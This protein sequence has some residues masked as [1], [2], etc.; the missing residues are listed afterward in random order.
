MQVTNILILI[1]GLSLLGRSIAEEPIVSLD[2][3]LSLAAPCAKFRATHFVVIT[4]KEHRYNPVPFGGES[5]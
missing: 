4:G 5:G 3:Y 1:I 2:I